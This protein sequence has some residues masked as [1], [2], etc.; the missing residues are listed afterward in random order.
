VTTGVTDAHGF[1]FPEGQNAKYPGIYLG[2]YRVEISKK[3]DGR[4][5]IP[6]KF[7]SETTLAIEAA[8]DA[9]SSQRL[10]VFDLGS[11]PR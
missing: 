8:P 5:T 4:E 1:A 3:E 10:F 11:Q 2:L 7:N 9:P 6:A